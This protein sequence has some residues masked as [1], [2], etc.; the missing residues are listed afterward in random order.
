VLCEKLGVR[1]APRAYR[2]TNIARRD[3]HR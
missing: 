3:A 2:P 1:C